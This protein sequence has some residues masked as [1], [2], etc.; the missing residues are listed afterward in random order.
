MV[1]L[2]NLKYLFS[3]LVIF[4]ISGM[5]NGSLAWLWSSFIE[6]NPPPSP[7][8]RVLSAMLRDFSPSSHDGSKNFSLDDGRIGHSDPSL[9]FSPHVKCRKLKK[10][11]VDCSEEV[12]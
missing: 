2:S 5:L 3:F 11:N 9:E 1:F 12:I 8:R 10:G 4:N 6:S 7:M